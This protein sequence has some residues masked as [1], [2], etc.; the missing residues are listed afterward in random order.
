M[1]IPDQSEFRQWLRDRA[2]QIVGLA[3][4]GDECPVA[5]WLCDV[6]PG[7]PVSVGFGFVFDR[8]HNT[9]IEAPHWIEDFVDA[10]DTNLDDEP[11][12][13]GSW[14]LAVLEDIGQ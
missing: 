8:R 5:R 11:A 1:I 6:N 14:C 2:L 10:V 4:Q 7:V 12:C 9:P 13:D 3:G